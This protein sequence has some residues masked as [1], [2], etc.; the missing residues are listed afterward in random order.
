MYVFVYFV[1][2]AYLLISSNDDADDDN[3]EY[4][5]E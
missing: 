2:V 5:Q 1:L 3:D 4:S